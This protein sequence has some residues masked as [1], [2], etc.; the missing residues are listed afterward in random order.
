MLQTTVFRCVFVVSVLGTIGL[1]AQQTVG[2][3]QNMPGTFKGYTLFAPLQNTDTYLIDDCGELVHSWESNLLPGSGV[4]L[5]GD[6]SLLR[7][8]RLNT[9]NFNA[10]GKGG[11][12][13]R[14]DWDGELIWQYNLADTTQQQHHDAAV[15]PSG[16]ILALVWELVSEE[17]AIAAGRDPETVSG[18]LWVDKVVELK[19]V[20]DN[21]AEIVWEWR[22]FDHL[23]QDFDSTKTNYG[24]VAEHPELMDFNYLGLTAGSPSQQVDWSHLNAVDYNET[25]DQI[26]VSS[27]HFS[28]IWVIDHSTTI[29]EAAGNTGGNSGRGGDILYRW[30]NPAVYDRGAE[31]DQQFFYQHDSR[32]IEEENGQIRIMV[33]NNGLG[34][35]G[36]NYSSVDILDPPLQPDGTYAID[37]G[38]FAPA[39]PSWTYSGQP[40]NPFYSLNISGAFW[41]ENG[42]ILVCEGNDGRL[43][44]IQSD[45]TLVWEYVNPTN[46]FGSIVQGNNPNGNALFKASKYAIDDPAFEGRNLIPLGPLE[47]D[48]LPSNCITSAEEA[49]TLESRISIYPNPATTDLILQSERWEEQEV[50][51]FNSLGQGL[52][53]LQ[54]NGQ[55]LQIFIGDLPKGLYWLHLDGEVLAFVKS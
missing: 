27:R 20:G 44:E 30:G 6:G 41:L 53:Q 51:I 17:E 19:P 9:A 34:R 49:L 7:L 38:A 2:L 36:G 43:F 42:N 54:W 46:N 14:L 31:I 32:W 28:E 11:R 21:E 12:L 50:Q 10:G 13:I 5:L 40:N 18:A 1:A 15:L 47:L 55:M 8:E 39:V 4:Y 26:V 48:P 25:L 37:A 35:P 45:G 24:V 16:N 52:R 29:E 22:L 33:F 23:I 3:F